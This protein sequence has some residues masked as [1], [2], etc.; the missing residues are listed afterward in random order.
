ME[1][2]CGQ[3]NTRM[4][5]FDSEWFKSASTYLAETGATF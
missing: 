5:I 4:Q 3:C 1:N 2:L